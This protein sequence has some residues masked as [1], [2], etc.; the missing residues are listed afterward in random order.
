MPEAT[1]IP[2][3]LSAFDSLAGLNRSLAVVSRTI[4]TAPS[5]ANL[6]MNVS[7]ANEV[8]GC[9]QA[10]DEEDNESTLSTPISISISHSM[11]ILLNRLTE[12]FRSAFLS[13]VAALVHSSE[14]DKTL[15]WNWHTLEHARNLFQHRLGALPLA[16]NRFRSQVRALPAG[17]AAWVWARSPL[18]PRVRRFDQQQHVMGGG[19]GSDGGWT[20]STEAQLPK[21]VWMR[22]PGSKNDGYEVES[23]ESKYNFAEMAMVTFVVPPTMGLTEQDFVDMCQSQ[24]VRSRC[25]L[26]RMSVCCL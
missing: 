25:F 11:P 9:T 17:W 15:G 13:T 2:A 12:V 16:Q 7:N 20:T 10:D 14:P 21:G 26:S 5:T 19:S 8:P 18:K 1:C 24:E 22:G 6:R 3:P 23:R 4:S